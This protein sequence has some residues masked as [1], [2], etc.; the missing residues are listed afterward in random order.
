MLGF[1]VQW[2]SAWLALPLKHTARP[3]SGP[4]ALTFTA[5]SDACIFV[6]AKELALQKV[7][8]TLISQ[9]TV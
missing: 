2:Q 8:L 5:P 7:L 1:A 9:G 3:G 6:H 4:Q